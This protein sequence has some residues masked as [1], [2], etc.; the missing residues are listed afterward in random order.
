MVDVLFD[1]KPKLK[2][3]VHQ[4]IEV[5]QR[6]NRELIKD[7]LTNAGYDKLSECDNN[8]DDWAD[9]AGGSDAGRAKAHKAQRMRVRTRVVAALW[10]EASEEERAIVLVE[11]EKEKE[12]LRVAELREEEA[13]KEKEKTPAQLQE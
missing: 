13:E 5:F 7:A 8:E 12:E 3:R 11:V 9:E 10:E 4:A 1:L 6:R 2:K